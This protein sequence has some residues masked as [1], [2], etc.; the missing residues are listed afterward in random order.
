MVDNWTC[1][2]CGREGDPAQPAPS[3]SCSTP[4]S[5]KPEDITVFSMGTY[6][7]KVCMECREKSGNEEL[8]DRI[9]AKV[10]LLRS[11]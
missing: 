10:S 9:R 11:T 6:S 3:C 2:I 7:L 4:V 5:P 8:R 1:E